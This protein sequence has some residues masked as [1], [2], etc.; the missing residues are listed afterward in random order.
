MGIEQLLEFHQ[1]CREEAAQ[2]YKELLIPRLE[3]PAWHGEIADAVREVEA[4]LSASDNLKNVDHALEL[5]GSHMYILRFLMAPPFSQD[6]FKI[7]C[8]SWVKAT[9]KTGKPLTAKAAS[10]VAAVFGEWA[11]EERVEPIMSGDDFDTR[12]EV[13]SATAHMMAVERYRTNR[14][15]RLAREQE[16]TVASLLRDLG[17]RLLQSRLV[18]Q[19]GALAQDEY[20]RATQFQTADGSTHEVDV[21]IGLPR[22]RILALECKVSNDATN[23]VKRVNDVLKKAGAWKRQWGR[24]VLTGA[25][26]QGVFSPKEPRRLLEEDVSVFWSHRPSDLSDWLITQKSSE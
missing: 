20:M 3:G 23:S 10:S 24:F 5:S 4:T 2:R 17:F 8:P 11:D 7:A 9:E 18:D 1:A 14:R 13:I 26:L 21:A 6:Q 12:G 15:M 16:E 22:R 19:P 25:M